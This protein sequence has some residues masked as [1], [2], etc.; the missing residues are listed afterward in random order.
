MI[1]VFWALCDQAKQII[2]SHRIALHCRRAGWLA[3]WLACAQ[4]P[5][6]MEF[7]EG[8]KKERKKKTD[9]GIDLCR[10]RATRAMLACI[11]HW[12]IS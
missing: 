11:A 1:I 3:G 6:S 5:A 2:A 9:S 8:G 12:T 7:L 4:A 10:F